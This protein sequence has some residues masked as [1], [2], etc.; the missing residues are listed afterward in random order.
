MNWINK[1]IG[2]DK[3]SK[4]I[5]VSMLIVIAPIVCCIFT[6]LFI[7]SLG[8]GSGISISYYYYLFTLVFLIIFFLRL[9]FLSL[10]FL[11]S[12]IIEL[13][14]GVSPYMLKKMDLMQINSFVPRTQSQRFI[15]HPTLG[16]IPA[17]GFIS[18]EI[19]HT[20]TSIR[21][22]QKPFNNTKKHIAV[23][24]GSTTYDIG[25]SDKNTWVSKL[26]IK[27]PNYSISNNGVPGYSTAEHL[28]QTAFYSNRAGS[29][30]VCA[31][32]F[33]GWNDIRNFA[34]NNLDYGYSDFHF[35]SQYGNLQ[36]RRSANTPSPVFNL[37]SIYFKQND[38]P[39][40]NPSGNLEK[41]VLE[42]DALF[43]I[44]NN[45]IN[46]IIALNSSRNINSMFIGQVLNRSKLDEGDINKA[47]KWIPFVDN[48]DTWE[49]QN[50][51]NIYI[52]NKLESK[53]AFFLMPDINNFDSNDFVDSGHFSNKG[54]E[55]F[56]NLV[57]SK[58]MLGCKLY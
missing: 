25:V 12:L 36:V 18:D 9:K 35:L 34:I 48:K 11:C 57:A 24:G 10:I 47:P 22:N 54:T 39:F 49:L 17:P 30:P 53:D 6:L 3:E 27:I 52:K 2:E 15:F 51:F 29:N 28:I 32:Y 20:S 23:F 44:A 45:N 14:M 16:A 46:S 1:L 42:K 38:L 55:K 37:M 43:E 13:I 26:D 5:S 58:L 7:R 21:M 56:S 41:N 19:N 40:P 8:I 50:R 4:F 31:I 33:I